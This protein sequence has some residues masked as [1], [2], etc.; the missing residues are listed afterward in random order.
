MSANTEV[1]RYYV[2][3]ASELKYLN[4]V[5]IEKWSYE[6]RYEAEE[7]A[8]HLDIDLPWREF[9]AE[10]VHEVNLSDYPGE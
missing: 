8:A 2:G 5:E 6:D 3:D 4:R 10:M 9:L 1:T 7:A